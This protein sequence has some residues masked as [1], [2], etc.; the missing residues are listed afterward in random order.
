MTQSRTRRCPTRPLMGILLLLLAWAASGPAGPAVAGEPGDGN[1]PRTEIGIQTGGGTLRFA[2][3]VAL[4]PAQQQRG[5]MFRAELAPDGGM[6]FLHE[7][8]RPVSMWMKNT[9]ISLDMLFL[10]ADG[11]IVRIAEKT[12]PLSTRTISSGGPVK[13]VLELRGGT[14]RKLGI[15]PGDRVVHPAF[16]PGG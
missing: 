12:E 10:A 1:F 16:S 3:E 14:S 4:T 9:L 15:V 6:L 7:G 5:L 2:V 8:E 13:G 11:T